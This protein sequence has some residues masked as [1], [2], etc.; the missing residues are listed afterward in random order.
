M[1]NTF[2]INK[3]VL[4]AF[5][6]FLNPIVINDYAMVCY[7]FIYGFP[8]AYLVL[9]RSFYN[10]FVRHIPLKALYILMFCLIMLVLSVLVPAIHGTWDF[11]YINVVLAVARKLLILL[12]LSSL[13]IK[14]HSNPKIDYVL[15]Y[16]ALATA[17]YV[18][19][20]CVFLAFPMLKESWKHFLG[21]TDFINNLYSSYGYAARFGWSGFSGYRN[22]LDCTLS[23]TFLV[24]LKTKKESINTN[25]IVFYLVLSFCILGN[26]FYGRLG[27][28]V[29]LICVLIGLLYTRK[30]NTKSILIILAIVTVVVL[31]LGYAIEKNKQLHEW[32]N[33]ATIPL[34]NF[35]KTGSFDNYSANH[36]LNDMIFMP[37][38][39]TL[40]F[41]D[42]LYTEPNST[43][44]YMLTDSG[45]MRQILFWGIG[46]TIFSYFSYLYGLS[47]IYKK[48]IFLCFELL[49]TFIAFEIKGEVYF[50][51]LPLVI[52]VIEWDHY[53]KRINSKYLSKA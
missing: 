21:A 4:L 46:G 37:E 29:S 50:E 5:M 49:I 19:G 10:S 40:L 1:D 16:Y 41:G 34:I 11:S 51:L 22:T 2:I 26:L 30:I 9:D 13:I 24:Y 47:Q 44:H 3:W 45:F 7:A 33:W 39:S 38:A 23:V 35:I 42:G 48:H 25:N 28:I 17:I 27:F 31:I 6:L 8:L 18:F 20:T 14:F 43:H 53:L 32:F 36:L 15:Y 52:I 12:F